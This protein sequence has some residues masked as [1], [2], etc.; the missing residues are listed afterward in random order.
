M[1]KQNKSAVF[2]YKQN[3]HKPLHTKKEE[4]TDLISVVKFSIFLRFQNI[5]FF[6]SGCVTLSPLLG[7]SKE[8]VAVCEGGFPLSLPTFDFLDSLRFFTKVLQV[9]LRLALPLPLHLSVSPSEDMNGSQLYPSDRKMNGSI[10]TFARIPLHTLFSI[11]DPKKTRR[12][13]DFYFLR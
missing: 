6:N 3:I 5:S 12:I 1:T 2:L 9:I 13:L 8:A 11:I 10:R 7:H 4:T